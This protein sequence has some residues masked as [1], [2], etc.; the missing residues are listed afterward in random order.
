MRRWAQ[1]GTMP[2]LHVLDVANNNM[3]GTVP[4]GWG[5]PGTSY[6]VSGQSASYMIGPG[7]LSVIGILPVSLLGFEG[8]GG[9]KL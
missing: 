5:V 6:F 2:R 1:P 3:S 7:P 4:G 9:M 8:C